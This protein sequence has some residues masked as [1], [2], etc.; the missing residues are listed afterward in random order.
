MKIIPRNCTGFLRVARS[1]TRHKHKYKFCFCMFVC[2][3]LCWAR[4]LYHV[5]ICLRSCRGRPHY[6]YQCFITWSAE[7]RFLIRSQFLR[8]VCREHFQDLGHS[9]SPHGSPSRP[10][11]KCHRHYLLLRSE[12]FSESVARE[13]PVRAKEQTMSKDKYLS[14]FS[15]QTEAIVFIIPQTFIATCALKIGHVRYVNIQA[16]LRGFRVKI[17]CMQAVGWSK[18]NRNT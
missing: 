10:T 11:T 5:L 3:C 14:I 6:R 2:F 7:C 18:K 1:L 13:K 16:W 9:F 15:R 8:M 4:P 17:A 12:Q